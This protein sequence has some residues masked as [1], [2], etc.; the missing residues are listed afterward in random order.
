MC[1]DMTMCKYVSANVYVCVCVFINIFKKLNI[2][3]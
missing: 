3:T 2:K 1:V